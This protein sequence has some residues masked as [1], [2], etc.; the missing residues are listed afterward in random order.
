MILRATCRPRVRNPRSSASHHRRRRLLR[1]LLRPPAGRGRSKGKVST[2][3]CWSWTGIRTARRLRDLVEAPT[4][5][6]VVKEWDAF[7]DAY[8]GRGPAGAD[9]PPEPAAMSS[10]PPHSCPTSCISGWFGGP[11]HGGRAPRSGSR[12]LSEGPGNAVR[13]RPRGTSIRLVRRLAL[14]DPLHRA[15]PCP[16]IRAPRT[17]EMTEAIE[18]SP[19]PADALRIAGAGPVR[20]APSGVRGGYFRR[21]EVLAG[22]TGWC[23]AGAPGAVDVCWS[24]PFLPATAP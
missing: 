6:L 4:A 5:E 17:W 7:F 2:G 1:D 10:S 14:S 20:G 21:P 18:R 16:V 9:P 3:G 11:G 8:L 22:T 23:G 13:R 15:G 24:G 12:A 19:V